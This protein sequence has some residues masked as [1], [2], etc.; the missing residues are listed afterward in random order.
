M[1]N[2]KGKV[3]KGPPWNQRKE[4]INQ[5][6]ERNHPMVDPKT[7]HQKIFSTLHPIN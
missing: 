5:N 3:F 2:Q 7:K 4:K 1:K 6:G